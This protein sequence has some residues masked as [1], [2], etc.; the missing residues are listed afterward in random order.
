MMSI[1]TTLSTLILLLDSVSIYPEI[2][3]DGGLRSGRGT[4]EVV[5]RLET[6]SITPRNQMHLVKMAQEPGVETGRI[7]ARTFGH[8]ERV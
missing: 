1:R 5:I 7:S 4:A 2:T 6:G 3:I 8:S